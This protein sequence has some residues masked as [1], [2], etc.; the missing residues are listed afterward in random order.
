MCLGIRVSPVSRTCALPRIPLHSLCSCTCAYGRR[1]RQT[2]M[3]NIE[4]R[5]CLN[6]RALPFP[7]VPSV[8]APASLP[9]HV[10]TRSRAHPGH[11]SPRAP[12]PRCSRAHPC[13]RTEHDHARIRATGT[14][15]PCA[16]LRPVHTVRAPAPRSVA[17]VRSRACSRPLVCHPSRA[18]PRCSHP[19]RSRSPRTLPTP[20]HCISIQTYLGIWQCRSGL[21]ETRAHSRSA[22][23]SAG[24]T[25]CRCKFRHLGQPL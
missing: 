11:P 9:V 19:S 23:V 17:P 3:R 2:R 5:A 8:R 1:M 7:H 18:L 13:E 15:R 22:H 14:V 20:S 16:S 6:S 21:R 24:Q 12:A 10:L 4:N 25:P